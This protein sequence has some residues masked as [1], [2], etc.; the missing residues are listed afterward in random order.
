MNKP[1]IPLLIL[2]AILGI[3]FAQFVIVPFLIPPKKDKIEIKLPNLELEIEKPRRMDKIDDD[4]YR[5]IYTTATT[6]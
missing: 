4:V 1:N 6:A 5:L 3:I 2:S